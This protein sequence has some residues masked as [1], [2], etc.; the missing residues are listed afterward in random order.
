[1]KSLRALSNISYTLNV[2]CT[3]ETNVVN[4]F[5]TIMTEVRIRRSAIRFLVG[6][7]DF[8]ILRDV[9]TDSGVSL[10]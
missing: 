9:Q 10:G 2:T 8:P 4:N 7:G 6:A 5:V 1:M 3:C